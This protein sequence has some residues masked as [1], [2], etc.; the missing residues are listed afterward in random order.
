MCGSIERFPGSPLSRRSALLLIKLG[1]SQR[2]ARANGLERW[3]LGETWRWSAA[4]RIRA[5]H[6]GAIM[7]GVLGQ[8]QN[9]K[10][11]VKVS[12]AMLIFYLLAVWAFAMSLDTPALL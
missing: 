3:K 6:S 8:Q 2:M 4:T 7:V 1:T 10:Q 12:A 9:N 11:R 5:L